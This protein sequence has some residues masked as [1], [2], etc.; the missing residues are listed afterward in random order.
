MPWSWRTVEYMSWA[1]RW[2]GSPTS[3]IPSDGE[4]YEANPGAGGGEQRL[5]EQDQDGVDAEVLFTSASHQTMWRGIREDDGYLALVRAFN[6]FLVEDYSA[7]APDRLLAM[8]VIPDTGVDDALAEMEY[9]ARAG[10]KGVCLKAFPNGKGFPLPEDDRF[11]KAAVDLQ[12]PITAHSTFSSRD[13]SGST[14]RYPRTPGQVEGSGADPVGHLT[15]FS[16]N[17]AR[18]VVQLAFAGVFDRF[19]ALNIYFAETQAGWIPH[20]LFQVDDN[21]ERTRYWAERFYGLEPLARLP[22][23][24]IRDHAYWGFLRDPVG[25]RLRHDIGV[26][27]LMWASDFPHAQGDWPNSRRVI[28]ETFVGVPEDERYRMLAGNAIDF[29]HLDALPIA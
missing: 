13:G 29:F 23:E 8:G 11:W 27:K 7:V 5:R 9:C 10:L 21:Y 24:Y 2:A 6:E 16:L 28:D 22:S 20:L 12:M 3:S 25:V 4:V 17:T 1:W 15:R 14:F 26:D 18:N 19:P